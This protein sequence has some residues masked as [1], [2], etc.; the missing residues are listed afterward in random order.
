MVALKSEGEERRLPS[1][2]LATA[3]LNDVPAVGV[4]VRPLPERSASETVALPVIV[5]RELPVSLT[6]IMTGKTPASEYVWRA[7]IL[8]APPEPVMTPALAKPSPQS[9]LALKSEGV[10]PRL[11]S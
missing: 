6:S 3:P 1:F 4:M 7:L 9:M 8:K 2:R 10:A 5:N 11:P